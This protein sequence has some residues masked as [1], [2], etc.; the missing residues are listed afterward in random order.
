MRNAVAI[1]YPLRDELTQ[2]CCEDE[3]TLTALSTTP[4]AH[5]G[6]YLYLFI[7][8]QDFDQQT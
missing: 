2:I 3:P 5:A 1:A 8:V 7:F 4:S 6:F